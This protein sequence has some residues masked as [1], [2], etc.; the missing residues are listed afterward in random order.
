MMFVRITVLSFLLVM[1]FLLPA[2]ACEQTTSAERCVDTG[3]WQFNL[4]MGAGHRSNPLHGGRNWPLWLLPDVSFYAQHW[5]FDNGT[6][7]YTFNPAANL[8]LSLVS[9]INEEAGL[10]RRGNPANIF[11]RQGIANVNG[12][13]EKFLFSEALQITQLSKR[14]YAL[15]GG[16]QLNWQGL[17]LHW[18]ANWWHDISSQYHGQHVKVGA[19]YGWSNR[20]GEWQ[21]STA[22]AWKDKDLMNTYYGIQASE[23]EGQTWSV[24]SDWQPEVALQWQYPLNERWSILSLW[25]YRWLDDQ[26]T[27]DTALTKSQNPIMQEDNLRSW[28]VGLNY[29]FF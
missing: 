28:F 12:P 23:H 5:F 15:D 24:S 16:L 9:R 20:T 6:A 3:V 17:G 19:A 29:R 21:L 25:R 11:Q 4:A 7:G 2:R 14:P 22:L 27:S 13:Q 26:A 18:Q 10:F 8:Q 1:L